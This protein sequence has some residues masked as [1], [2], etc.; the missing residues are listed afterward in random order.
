MDAFPAF[1]A[2]L[3]AAK[4][5]FTLAMEELNRR[6]ALE[7]AGSV[8]AG[9]E[10]FI[11][12]ETY[13]KSVRYTAATSLY[14]CAEALWSAVILAVLLY[15]G[16]LPAL[17]NGLSSAFGYSIW[18]QAAALLVIGQIVD[19]ADWPLDWWHTFHV[20]EKF[21]FNK[22][23]AGLWLADK[24][25]G[26]VLYVCL[27][28]PI[29]VVLLAL[30]RVPYWWV[31]GFACT[32]LFTLVLMVLYPMFILPLFNKFTPLPEGE[33]KER[34]MSLAARTGFAAKTI[35]VMDGS[36]RS[37]HSNAFFA[38]VGRTRRVVLF[39]T[40]ISQLSPEELESVLAHEIGHYKLGHIPRMIGVSAILTFLSFALIGWL[41][42]CPWFVTSFGFAHDPARLAPVLLLF[43]LLSGPFLF[44]LTPLFS[45]VSRRQE[46]QADAFAKRALSGDPEP[47]IGALRKLHTENLGNLVPHPLYSS[48]HYSHPTLPEREAALRGSSP[49]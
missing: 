14:N 26:I 45:I 39:D 32:F 21:G 47:L 12:L 4:V 19:F 9:M 15:S 46:Y 5:L 28:Y 23:G 37:G 2:V 22:S 10:G 6:H 33:L 42:S 11:D 16:I 40:L 17:Y 20:E 27:M 31:W 25:K 36:R 35:L 34:L 48:F 24:G 7:R 18:G 49:A 13:G 44:W 30:I 41:A 43:S 29:A 38:G 8:P 1:V 3:I